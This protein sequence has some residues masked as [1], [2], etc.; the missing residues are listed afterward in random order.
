VQWLLGGTAPEMESVFFELQTDTSSEWVPLGPGNRIEGGWER[1]GLTLPPSGKLR[2]LG[3]TGGSLIE[4]ITPILTPIEYWRQMYFH[5]A[6]SAGDAADGADPDKDG[7]TNLLEYAFGFSPLQPGRHALPE[8][9]LE[10]TAFTAS[11]ALVE[12]RPDI[13]YGA[14]WSHSLDE[15]TW[16]AIP[17]TGSE[18]MHVFRVPVAGPRVFVRFEVSTR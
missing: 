4:S 18:G 10:G 12:E 2:A 6:E 13:I 11:F 14:S 3:R 7:L 1:N 8:F 17:D 16:T 5:S 9:K 15:S